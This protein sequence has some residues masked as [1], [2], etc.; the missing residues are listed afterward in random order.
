MKFVRTVGF[1]R[2]QPKRSLGLYSDWFSAHLPTTF[3]KFAS[4]SHVFSLADG[5]IV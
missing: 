5:G 3:L 1:L 2:V 4:I